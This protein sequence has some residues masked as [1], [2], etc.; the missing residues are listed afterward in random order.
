[1]LEEVDELAV[2]VSDKDLEQNDA[3]DVVS[4][5]Q[6][7]QE[8]APAEVKIDAEMPEQNIL[9]EQDTLPKKGD[10]AVPNKTDE[11]DD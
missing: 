6:M 2:V 8:E 5:I 4:E 1:M 7:Q 10:V 11:P 9:S 3:Q